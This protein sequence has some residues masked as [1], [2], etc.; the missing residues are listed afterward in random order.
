MEDLYRKLRTPVSQI[1]ALFALGFL[2]FSFVPYL[3]GGPK[4]AGLPNHLK[5]VTGIEILI[6]LISLLPIFIKKQP[7]NY[8]SFQKKLR[9]STGVCVLSFYNFTFVLYNAF[10]IIASHQGYNLYGIW[11]IG[12]SAMV[13]SYFAHIGSILLFLRHPDKYKGKTRK[14]RNNRKFIWIISVQLLSWIVYAQK[15]VEFILVPNVWDNSFLINVTN[16]TILSINATCI[17]IFNE[18]IK[19]EMEYR[20]KYDLKE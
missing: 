1:V 11:I 8:E 17:I 14:E 19:A 16:F 18:Y 4:I 6:C 5:I 10:Y 15:I 13:L 7:K 20:K 3:Y 9:I 2:L 12:I